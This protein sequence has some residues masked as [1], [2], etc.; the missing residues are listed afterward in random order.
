[1]KRTG[2][3]AACAIIF[4]VSSVYCQL[5]L[6]YYL[7]AASSQGRIIR[8]TALTLQYNEKYRQA[9]WVIYLL[10]ASRTQGKIKEKGEFGADPELKT[11]AVQPG[12][13]RGSGYDR[14]QLVSADDMRWSKTAFS[15]A[16]YMSVVSP[17]KTQFRT[18]IW[19]KL[20]TLT[21]KWAVDNGDIYVVSGP[22]FSDSPEL[23]KSSGIPV[24]KSFYR[25]IL[26][27]KDKGARGIGFFLPAVGADKPPMAY[28]MSIESVERATGINFF[29]N[30]PDAV[31][32]N[33]ETSF[34]PGVWFSTAGNDTSAVPPVVSSPAQRKVSAKVFSP[35]VI[36]K[37]LMK[38]G[39][40]CMRMTTNPN[41]FCWEHQ[42]QANQPAAK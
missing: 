12:D 11:A 6:E 41:G 23:L 3:A 13:F 14:G 15:E 21:R 30:L 29:P 16:C 9:D 36:C 32:K 28:A 22:V 26:E 24:P 34:A 35:A 39:K 27:A 7:P 8:H 2:I 42:D 38:D 20:D 25:V 19:A 10:T 5:P 40:H 4:G 1:M 37:G 33:I 18:G 17:M 31:E